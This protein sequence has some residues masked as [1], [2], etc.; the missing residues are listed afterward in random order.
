[1][2][3]PTITVHKYSV[4]V[5]TTREQEEDFAQFNLFEAMQREEARRA[6]LTPKQRA[7]EDATLNAA[8]A[9]EKAARTCEHCGCDP[10]AHGG[11]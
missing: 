9:A 7:D 6:A 1:M 5:Q 8:R 4:I 3:E 10:D 11:Y 2:S